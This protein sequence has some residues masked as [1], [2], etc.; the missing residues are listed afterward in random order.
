M[1]C[2]FLLKGEEP[3]VC[4]LYNTFCFV[5]VSDLIEVRYQHFTA[6]PLRLLF[7]DV[8]V[9]YIFDYMK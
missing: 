6:W 4:I 9:E 1:A 8:S 5:F 3:P 2:S 7:K